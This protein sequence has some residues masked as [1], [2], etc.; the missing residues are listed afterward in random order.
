MERLFNYVIHMFTFIS[1]DEV[2]R[3]LCFKM[4]LHVFHS[5]SREQSKKS[6]Q[7]LLWACCWLSQHWVA[8][9]WER[10]WLLDRYNDWGAL[11]L[12]VTV[13][14]PDAMSRQPQILARADDASVTRW[15]TALSGGDGEGQ[16]TG[17]TAFV[18]EPDH[19]AKDKWRVRIK[20]SIIFAFDYTLLVHSFVLEIQLR[21]HLH[22]K[23]TVHLITQPYVARYSSKSDHNNKRFSFSVAAKV[24]M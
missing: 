4:F 19:L 9:L 23:H 22:I 12:I 21:N 11:I 16:W 1:R 20:S 3:N 14:G 2:I 17:A 6:L 8:C 10:C 15:T 7:S 24:S 13:P 5:K 18:W